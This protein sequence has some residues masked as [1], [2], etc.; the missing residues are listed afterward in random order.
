MTPIK[1]M[2][3]FLIAFALY[4]LIVLSSNYWF[5][6]DEGFYAISIFEA[7]KNGPQLYITFLG[8]P[9]FW[10]P[11]LMIDVYAMLV[12]PLAS[13]LPPYTAY[14]IPSAL[15]SAINV[16]LVYHISKEFFEEKKALMISALYALNPLILLFG[17]KVFME[18]LT[19]SFVFFGLLATTHICKKDSKLDW[20]SAFLGIA[21]AITGASFSKSTTIGLMAFLIYGMYAFLANRKKIWVI[22]LAGV[23]SAAVVFIVPFLT[24]FP[25][26]FFKLYMEDFF[27]RRIDFETYPENIISMAALSS[28]LIPLLFVSI[29]GIRK[30]DSKELFLVLWV[31]PLPVI[32]LMTPYVWY[33]YYF[34]L[35]LVAISL[36]GISPS[37]KIDMAIVIAMLVLGLLIYAGAEA[38][39]S[40]ISELK[41]IEYMEK[42]IEREQCILYVGALSPMTIAYLEVS[43]HNFNAIINNAAIDKKANGTSTIILDANLT[44]EQLQVAVYDYMNVR[45]A[46]DISNRKYL[47]AQWKGPG[48]NLRL[49]SINKKC[50]DFEYVIVTDYY[51]RLTIN[52][53]QLV[54]DEDQMRVWK[55]QK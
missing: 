26:A 31:L 1:N 38:S 33:G 2:V 27:T 14:R 34:V 50:S 49:K 3:L 39:H 36:M 9:V 11:F 28:Y 37:N 46:E 55:R 6:G 12:Q 4:L 23:V 5:I 41:T 17:T 8:T 10:K 16:V 35:P 7:I 52:G 21:L 47:F 30:L 24:K 51:K 18:S 25:D 29:L 54:S 40:Q 53:Y 20:V 43:G 13:V 42:H 19:M 48:S 44:Q 32:M 22:A 45:F 15:F